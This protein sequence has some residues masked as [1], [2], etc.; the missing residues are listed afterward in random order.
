MTFL[1]CFAG[2]GLGR[3]GMEQAGH[4]CVGYIEID[5]YARQAYEA[6]FDTKGEWSSHD[7]R[8]A[9]PGDMPDFDCFLFGW[10]CQDNS[11]AGKR[12]G[13][14]EGTRSGLLYKA[15]GILRAKRPR[16][17][18]AENVKGLYT[19]THGVDFY[20]TIQEFTDSGYDVQWQ[21][22]NTI[23]FLPQN[24]E[25]YFFVGNLRGTPCPEVFPIGENQEIS[26]GEFTEEQE[27]QSVNCIVASQ[28]KVSTCIKKTLVIKR[29]GGWRT[30]GYVEVSP[31]LRAHGTGGNDSIP[32]IVTQDRH[33]LREHKGEGV[34]WLKARMA[35]GGNNVPMIVQRSQSGTRRSPVC[36]TL[37]C[38]ASR[39][40]NF[41]VEDGDRLR[42]L[43]PLEYFRLQG[44]PDE[45]WR[46][47]KEAGISDTQL[48]KIAGNG[49]SVPVVYE[50]ARRLPERIEARG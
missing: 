21:L 38:E 12:A 20:A 33:E 34:P 37:R 23:W 30:T 48:Y 31:T 1:D 18:I 6:Y 25:R 22:L 42:R 11:I 36:G 39:S 40:S 15:T 8:T 45:Y 43:T 50:V 19:N 5:K 32:I 9:D 26:A 29:A 17:F 7:I 44:A 35:T 46:K 14:G 16:Y 24:R 41:T 28:S 27:K 13:Q 47:A 2:G 10:P 3:L 49:M 4:K